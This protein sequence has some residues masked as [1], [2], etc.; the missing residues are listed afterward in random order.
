MHHLHRVL[1]VS[2]LDGEL[3]AG[4]SAILGVFAELKLGRHP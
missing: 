1:P 3:Y 4:L 2:D